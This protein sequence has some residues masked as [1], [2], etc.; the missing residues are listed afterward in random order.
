[1]N[2]QSVV[3]DFAKSPSCLFLLFVLC[4]F[5]HRRQFRVVSDAFIKIEGIAEVIDEML[6][7][8]ASKW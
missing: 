2:G 6:P 4:F 1:M 3:L 8:F 7:K 5:C